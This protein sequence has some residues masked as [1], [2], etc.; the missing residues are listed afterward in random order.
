M[1]FS[2]PRTPQRLFFRAKILENLR[3]VPVTSIQSSAKAFSS[4][5]SGSTVAFHPSETTYA[6][7]KRCI[8][9]IVKQHNVTMTTGPHAQVSEPETFSSFRHVSVASFAGVRV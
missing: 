4:K 2:L 6:H 9:T 8:M 1:Q 3:I 5:R 7:R